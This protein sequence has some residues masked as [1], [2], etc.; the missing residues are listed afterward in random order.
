MIRQGVILAG[1]LGSRLYNEDSFTPK[2]LIHVGGMALI[3]RIIVL[4]KNAGI[5]L[6]VIVLGHQSEQIVNFIRDRE[7]RGIVTVINNEYKKKNGIS[8][9]RSRSILNTEEPFLLSMADH[10]FSDDFF[11]EFIKRSKSLINNRSAVLSVD[12]NINGVFDL[13]DATKVLIKSKNIV[14]IGKYL[15]LYNAIDTGLFICSHS[16]FVELEKIYTATGDV[17]ISDGMNVLAHKNS[18]FA[19]DMTGYLWQDVDT[20]EMK[21]EAEKRLADNKKPT[22]NGYNV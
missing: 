3:E 18:F 15:D 8:L 6:I 11:T 21:K 2:P 1:G 17:S 5:E 9:L 20:P 13:D 14:K 12:R 10:V 19:A 4:M 22:C 7:Y 16:I